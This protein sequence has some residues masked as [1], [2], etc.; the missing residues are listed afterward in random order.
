MNVII[1]GGTGFIGIHF[2]RIYLKENLESKI[3]LVDIKDIEERFLFDDIKKAIENKQIEYI[4]ADV[5]NYSIFAKLPEKADLICN[6]AAIH[7]EPGHNHQEYFQTNLPGA[8]NICRYA[9]KI[10]CKNI[11]FTSSIA[12]YYPDETE[13]TEDSIPAP[14][15]AYG[16]SKLAAEK[17]H[18]TWQQKDP[19]N[20][21]LVIV[22]PG[23]VFGPGEGGNVTRMIKAIHKHYFVFLGNKNTKKASIYVKE[24]CNIMLFFLTKAKTE[25]GFILANAVSDNPVKIA[26]YV[27][28]VRKTRNKN[29]FVP[30]IPYAILYPISF[31]FIVFGKNCPIHPLRIKKLRRSNNILPVT[32]KKIG[33]RYIYT[34][35]SAFSDWFNEKPEDWK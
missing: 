30:N 18:Q 20:R 8:E 14:I 3:Y 17:I 35:K 12:P 10:Q 23:V 6:F 33:Y 21:N 9:E 27:D 11:I 4:N 22:R 34:L 31:L 26:N 29:Y 5:R 2:T 13:K 19:E 32:L 24:L 15:S 16:A 7:R 1:F 25:H 28:A